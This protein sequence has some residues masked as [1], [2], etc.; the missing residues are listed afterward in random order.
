MAKIIGPK[1]IPRG[2]KAAG[3]EHGT[4]LK[5]WNKLDS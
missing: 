3:K 5:K 2:S 4:S 1:R